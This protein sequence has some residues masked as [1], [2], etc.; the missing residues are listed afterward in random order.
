MQL[1]VSELFARL[2]NRLSILILL[3]MAI[4]AQSC[5]NGKKVYKSNCDTGN[6]FKHIGFTQLMDSLSYYNGRYIEVTGKYEEGKEQS[7]LFNDSL[8]MDHSVTNALWVDF[9]PDCPLYLAGTR[10]GLFEYSDG[11]FTVISGKTITIRGRL[12][13]RS[14]GH[15]NQYKATIGRLSLIRL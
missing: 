5:N 3:V 1:P 11:Q 9:S 6:N 12:D 8:M 7:A 10:T 4:T 2:P 14:K 13:T 15:L